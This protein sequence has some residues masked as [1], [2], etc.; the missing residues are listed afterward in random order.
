[1]RKDWLRILPPA[2][3]FIL[4]GDA[5]ARAK[6]SAV[7]EVPFAETACRAVARGSRATLWLGPNEYLLMDQ[8]DSASS[9]LA[10]AIEQALHDLPHAL[11]DISHRQIAVEIKGPQAEPIL[12]GGCPLDVDVSAFPVGGCTRTVFAKADIVLWRTGADT[13]Q[14]EVWRSFSDYLTALLREIAREFEV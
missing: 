11:V 8:T 14:L 1:M 3:R 9:V 10:A 6:A 13:F 7:W 12:S 5:A 4:H 2:S